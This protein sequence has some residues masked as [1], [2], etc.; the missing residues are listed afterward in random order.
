MYISLL[1][2]FSFPEGSHCPWSNIFSVNYDQTIR[3]EL[4]FDNISFHH[5]CFYSE[6]IIYESMTDFCCECIQSWSLCHVLNYNLLCQPKK[7]Q[8]LSHFD[9]ANVWSKSESCCG[10]AAALVAVCLMR[11]IRPRLVRRQYCVAFVSQRSKL[12]IIPL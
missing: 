5:P 3:V 12:W 11:L 9:N 7:V 1:V 10:D 4:I 2:T 6:K 8:T